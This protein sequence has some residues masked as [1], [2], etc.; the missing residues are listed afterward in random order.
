[1]MGDNILLRLILVPKTEEIKEGRGKL[2]NKE[3][4]ILCSWLNI[5]GVIKSRNCIG[6][7]YRTNLKMRKCTQYSG[8]GK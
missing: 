2:Y 7:L 5:F 8:Q 3:P 4:H 1:M 6:R